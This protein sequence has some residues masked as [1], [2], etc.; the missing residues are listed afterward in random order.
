MIDFSF[1]SLDYTTVPFYYLQSE[2]INKGYDPSSIPEEVTE[3]WSDYKEGIIDSVESESILNKYLSYLEKIIENIISKKSLLYWLHIIRR[4]PPTLIHLTDVPETSGNVRKI[5]EYSFHKYAL[6]NS[7]EHIK[8]R[9]DT[10]IE[11]I[12]NGLL[13]N[14]AFKKER[15]LIIN[16]GNQV[17]LLD[18]GVPELKEIFLIQK[19]CFQIWR[20]AS[21]FRMIAK[22]AKLQ[23]DYSPPYYFDFRDEE[24]DFLVKNF[25]SRVQPFNT[26]KEGA[27]FD[28]SPLNSPVFIPTYNI[29]KLPFN[30]YVWNQIFQQH[31]TLQDPTYFNFYWHPIELK[32]IMNAHN[33]LSECF[34]EKFGFKDDVIYLIL[35]AILIWVFEGFLLKN[36][37]S[38][39]IKMTNRA[40]SF[41]PS[42]HIIFER[43]KAYLEPS[44]NALDIQRQITVDEIEKGIEFLQ[45]FWDHPELIDLRYPTT[46]SLIINVYTDIVMLDLAWI[47]EA[48]FNLYFSVN[49]SDQNIKGVL[50]EELINDSPGPLPTSRLESLN[51]SY[52]QIDFSYCIGDI[53]VI[54]ECKA[55]GRAIDFELGN[56]NTIDYRSEEVVNRSLKEADEKVEW[57][58]NNP[59][60]RQY[61][62]SKYKY[63]LP[64]GIS[65][66]KEY[67]HSTDDYFWINDSLPRVLTPLELK[68]LILIDDFEGYVKHNLKKI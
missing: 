66:F 5:M 57:L 53:L 61:D 44:K 12:L 33:Y 41:V 38:F 3:F 51:G 19:F 35:Q 22:G 46:I 10:K 67:I 68:N 40:F 16:G 24:L 42:M 13:M 27:T 45:R 50:L 43:I 15:E 63:I 32:S 59:I 6:R 4:I 17:L 23:I 65:P 64:I 25:D 62:I 47:R 7:C 9:D 55:V 56:K 37:M 36:D 34:N 11:K 8:F 31:Y 1:H 20:V 30:T 60:G 21:L 48:I 14:D 52:K 39:F 26:T 18:F 2:L 29:N 54:G 28:I 49:V 58:I